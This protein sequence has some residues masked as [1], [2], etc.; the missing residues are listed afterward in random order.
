MSTV[1]SALGSIYY[2]ESEPLTFGGQDALRD[3]VLAAAKGITRV[4]LADIRPHQSP[5]CYVIFAKGSTRSLNKYGETLCSGQFPIY[6][7]KAKLLPD[8]LSRH[9]RAIVAA[10]GLE[11][12]DFS[13]GVI[14]TE[15]EA[16]AGAV[17]AMLIEAIRPPWN[18]RALSGFGSR[19]PGA[20]RSDQRPSGFDCLHQ[21][22]WVQVPTVDE[23]AA[24]NRALK[25]YLASG[26]VRPI[27]PGLES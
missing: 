25:V 23:K 26:Y 13:V 24:A 8:R 17:E 10:K 19:D 5:G 14:Y 12:G 6:I 16:M 18:E 27:W 2:P 9:R 7:G 1:T 3:S 15:T 20:T 22:D 11:V 4:S 21:R